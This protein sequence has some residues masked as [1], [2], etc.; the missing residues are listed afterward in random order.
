MSLRACWGLHSLT[1]LMLEDA[2][3]SLY[4]PAVN[5]VMEVMYQEGELDKEE[6]RR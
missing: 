1:Q 6:R 2:V 4:F 5:Y 3:L